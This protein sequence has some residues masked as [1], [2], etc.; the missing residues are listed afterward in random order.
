MLMP[1][2]KTLP[3]VGYAITDANGC[4][5]YVMERE[6]WSICVYYTKP[7]SGTHY[8]VWDSLDHDTSRHAQDVT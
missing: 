1:I 3:Q 6:D 4:T 7:G 8:V 2:L 5:W